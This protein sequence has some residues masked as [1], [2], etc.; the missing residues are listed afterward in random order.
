MK[1]RSFAKALLIIAAMLP[2]LLGSSCGTDTP[3]PGASAPELAGNWSLVNAATTAPLGGLTVDA[4]GALIQINGNPDLR[5]LLDTETVITDGQAVSL[6]G[7]RAYQAYSSLGLDDR[8]FLME[9]DVVLF[10]SNGQIGEGHLRLEGIQG[11]TT[12]DI[13]GDYSFNSQGPGVANRSNTALCRM[14][15]S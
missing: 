4:G 1:A 5:T 8:S 2:G 14:S 11:T 15:R 12:D 3:N 10:D 7:G 13:S 9:I 6:P